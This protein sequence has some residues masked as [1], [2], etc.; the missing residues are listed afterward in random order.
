MYFMVIE[1]NLLWIKNVINNGV[2]VLII[3][4]CIFCK[5]IRIF[6]IILDNINVIYVNIW[7]KNIIGFVY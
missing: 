2:R 5:K 7:K 4:N 6:V 3:Y 1:C